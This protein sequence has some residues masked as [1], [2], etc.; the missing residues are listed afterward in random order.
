MSA[1]NLVDGPAIYPGGPI[2]AFALPY[3][4]PAPPNG[5]R[6]PAAKAAGSAADAMAT[7]GPRASAIEGGQ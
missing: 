1:L 6:A 4:I 2:M 3:G 5:V 7:D